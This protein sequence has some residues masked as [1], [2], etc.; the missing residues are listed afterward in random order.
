MTDRKIL[1]E[2]RKAG[3][4]H[5]SIVQPEFD[6][7]E[8]EIIDQALTALRSHYLKE[9]EEKLPQAK[10]VRYEHTKRQMGADGIIVE[11]EKHIKY[12]RDEEAYN[13]ALADCLVVVKEVL[14]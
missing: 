11:I 9:I 3:N 2:F 14:G 8:N 1:R 4:P 13:Q 6:E 7:R 12:D 5:D 10:P